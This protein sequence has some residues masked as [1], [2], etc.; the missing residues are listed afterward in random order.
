MTL[1]FVLRPLAAETR[2][3]Y[4]RAKAWARALVAAT[5][6]FVVAMVIAAIVRVLF[7]GSVLSPEGYG[8]AF[9]AWLAVT[10]L[11]ISVVGRAQLRR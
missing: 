6:V 7:L 2:L 9:G 11:A 5:L 4:D 3:V 8:L 1:E 10:F